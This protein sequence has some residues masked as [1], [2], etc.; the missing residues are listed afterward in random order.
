[1]TMSL[2]GVYCT[3]NESLYAL[4]DTI[5]NK[6]IVGSIL[7]SNGG[8]LRF[9]LPAFDGKSKDAWRKSWLLPSKRALV[10]RYGRMARIFEDDRCALIKEGL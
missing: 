7:Q 2:D 6:R 9:T 1:M 4:F 10:E 8:N 5:F 3:D